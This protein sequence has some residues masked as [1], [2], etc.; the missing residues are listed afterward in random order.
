[1]GKQTDREVLLNKLSLIGDRLHVLTST[2]M[3]PVNWPKILGVLARV[4]EV[5]VDFRRLALANGVDPE[6]DTADLDRDLADNEWETCCWPFVDGFDWDFT[7][8]WPP[9]PDVLGDVVLPEAAY[10]PELVRAP[11]PAAAAPQPVVAPPVAA[12]PREVRPKTS[13]GRMAVLGTL[14]TMVAMLL[15][16]AQGLD[17]SRVLATVALH[18]GRSEG[19]AIVAGVVRDA[20]T[21]SS[22]VSMGQLY[23]IADERPEAILAALAAVGEL[24][25]TLTVSAQPVVRMGADD[26]HVDCSP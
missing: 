16:D 6:L 26:M 13:L 9:P 12:R 18:S 8:G 21:G 25:D 14:S 19:W 22:T 10:A 24:M 17:A 2:C 7:M 3:E 20:L 1:M 4:D 11:R 15:D 5:S 23:R